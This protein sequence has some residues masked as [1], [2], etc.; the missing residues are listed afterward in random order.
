M[1]AMNYLNGTSGGILDKRHFHTK[2]LSKVENASTHALHI[3]FPFT[4]L[5]QHISQIK[6]K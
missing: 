4:F 2:F 1:S 6:L 3:K 5:R